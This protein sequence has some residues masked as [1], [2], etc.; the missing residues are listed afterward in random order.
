[1]Y[2][3][4]GKKTAPTTRITPTTARTSSR[5]LGRDRFGGTGGG[6]SGEDGKDGEVNGC[7]G[8]G[9]DEYS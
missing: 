6:G 1:M 4:L 5:I 8:R 3:K 7:G 2:E 9:I